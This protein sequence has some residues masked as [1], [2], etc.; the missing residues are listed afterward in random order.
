MGVNVNQILTT[1]QIHRASAIIAQ[2]ATPLT[3]KDYFHLA[4]VI[5]DMRSGALPLEILQ[6]AM[7]I[8]KLE[9]G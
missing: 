3:A 6:S 2:C 8:C 7:R 5:A 1:A 9:M 4:D